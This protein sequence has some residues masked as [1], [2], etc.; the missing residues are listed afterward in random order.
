MSTFTKTLIA[1]AM[2][3]AVAGPVSADVPDGV[4]QAYVGSKTTVKLKPSGC[5]NQNTKNIDTIVGFGDIDEFLEGEFDL[6][7]PFAGCWAMAGFQ[8]YDV[9]AIAGMRISRKTDKKTLTAKDLTMSLTG[10][11]LYGEVI[12][13]IYDYLY[14]E[15]DAVK[16]GYVDDDTLWEQAYIKK[17]NGKFSKNQEKL[18]IDIQVDSQYRNDK[19][20]LKNVQASIKGKLDLSNNTANPAFDCGLIFIN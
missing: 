12:N 16:C 17:G 6:Y 2:A 18:T 7:L 3:V 9:D 11:S 13:G 20:K 14:Y 15:D 4:S 8:F 19:D 1:S 5:K 10:E